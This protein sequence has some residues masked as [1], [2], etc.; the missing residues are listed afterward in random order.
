MKCKACGY[1]YEID[2]STLSAKPISGD[3]KFIHI[4]GS[5]HVENT[6]WNYGEHVV[7]L[8]AC[9]KCNTVILND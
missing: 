3:E 2:Y 8:M 4:I 1:E 6:G 5:F 7:S 9:P